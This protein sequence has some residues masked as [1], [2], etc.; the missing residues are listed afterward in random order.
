MTSERRRPHNWDQLTPEIRDAIDR[1]MARIGSPSGV[2][3]DPERCRRLASL[4]GLRRA[5]EPS[6]GGGRDA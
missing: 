3:W 5:L 2:A 4:L 6:D 1:E